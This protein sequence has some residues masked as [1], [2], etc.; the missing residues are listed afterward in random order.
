MLSS[1]TVFVVLGEPMYGVS[2]QAFVQQA[3][4]PIVAPWAAP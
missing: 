1:V 4:I 2:L 3:L